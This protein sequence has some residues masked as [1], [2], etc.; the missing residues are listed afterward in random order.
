M[1][2][3]FY[4]PCVN[5][6]GRG[7]LADAGREIAAMGLKKA[8]I[9]TDAPLHREMKATAPLIDL[10]NG[11]GVAH[12]VFDGVAPNPTVGQVNAGL[13]QYQAQGCDFIISFGGG[14]PHDA[15]KG[16]GILAGNGGDIRAY[17]GVNK[18]ARP[19]PPLVAINTTAGTASEMTR[20]AIITDEER[21]VKMAIVDWRTTPTLSVDDP[22]LMEEMPSG[23][24]AA[25]GMDALTHAIEAY[26]S[27]AA[28]PVTDAAA[29]HAM[30]LVNAYLARAVKDG[31][32]HEAR[33]MMAY[34]QFLAGMAFN[35]ASLGYVHAM[36]H[37]L[38]GFYDLPHGVCN[39]ILLPH[40]ERANAEENPARFVEI[41]A[42]LGVSVTGLSPA[43]AAEGALARIRSLAVEVGIPPNLAAFD[44]VKP[45]DFPTLADNAM[46]DACGATNPRRLMRTEIIALFEAAYAEDA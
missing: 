33:D 14:S 2:S 7:G 12:A 11:I 19:M 22:A 4:M 25:T 21:H 43:E 28:T 23:L 26:V 6:L 36:A 30:R 46:K 44:I 20:F 10:L 1:G 38:G 37:Q 5:I 13:A 27:T 18:S 24:T 31:H 15:A 3:Y 39:A 17:E 29:L 16:I 8:L 34:A 9:V 35:S 41:A 40:V 32:D 42:A 45:A